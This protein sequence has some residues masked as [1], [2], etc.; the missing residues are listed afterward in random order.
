MPLLLQAGRRDDIV[1]A[2][3]VRQIFDAAPEPKTYEEYGV[4]HFYKLAPGPRSRINE[5]TVKFFLEV[6]AR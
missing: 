6:L 3:R 1:P 5:A 4:N 2:E